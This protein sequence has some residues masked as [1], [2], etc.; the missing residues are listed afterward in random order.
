M[1]VSY[2]TSMN[3][4]TYDPI[5][6]NI[7]Y[8]YDQTLV[9]VSTPLTSDPI[10]MPN[11]IDQ[12]A[13]TLSITAGEG[14]VQTTT[15]KLADVISGTSVVWHDWELGSIIATDQ[16]VAAPVTAMRF[17]CTT[18]TVRVMIKAQ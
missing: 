2:M 11:N 3:I 15:N 10:I 16:D 4:D 1:A 17:I 7:S 9:Y 12:I 14:K 18:G 8:E 5:I 6:K 13:V